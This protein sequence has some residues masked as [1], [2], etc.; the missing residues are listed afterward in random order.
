MELE[1]LPQETRERIDKIGPAALVIGLPGLS[2]TAAL[3]AAIPVI[4]SALAPLSAGH[5]KAVVAH[6]DA[7]AFGDPSQNGDVP[8][9]NENLRLLPFPLFPADR[10]HAASHGSS[11]T[12]LAMLALGGKLGAKATVVLADTEVQSVEKLQRLAEPIL[13]RGLDL[14]TPAYAHDKFEGLINSG[15]VYPFNR[16]LYGRRI[17]GQLGVDFGFSAGIAERCLQYAPNAVAPM[18]GSQAWMVIEAISGGFQIGEAFLGRRQVPKEAGDLSTVLAQ[19]LGPI[20]I[21][22]ERTAPFWQKIR[23]SQAVPNFGSPT[24]LNEPAS[25]VDASPMIASFQL[26]FRNLQEVWGIVLS[27]AT[28]LELKK[29]TR[30]AVDQFRLPD[31]LWVRIVYDFALAYHLRVMNRDQLLR[32]M[33]PLYLAWVGSYALAVRTAEPAQAEQ[34]IEKLCMAYEAQK[35]YLQSRWRW[36]DRFNP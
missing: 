26:G 18:S 16:A 20:F 14:V 29:L 10:F 23:G 31:E 15:I 36:P 24:L 3:R 30:S 1:A 27:P 32:S 22:M 17:R 7:A 13:L 19:T 12:Y 21:A 34:R 11:D 33:T 4:E 2:G 8:S 25:E 28:M 6:N 35:P 9:G 5:L